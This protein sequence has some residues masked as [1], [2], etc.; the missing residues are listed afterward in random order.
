MGLVTFREEEQSGL[1]VLM[2]SR[3]PFDNKKC[4]QHPNGMRRLTR[5]T[6]NCGRDNDQKTAG[7]ISPRRATIYLRVRALLRIV[8]RSLPP[9]APKAT[10]FG[11]MPSIAK[12]IKIHPKTLATQRAVLNTI[13]CSLSDMFGTFHKFESRPPATPLQLTSLNTA[14]TT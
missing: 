3:N 6:S 4:D 13:R 14:A 12:V 10:A 9:D 2:Q 7:T 11:G 8:V 5:E 1:R